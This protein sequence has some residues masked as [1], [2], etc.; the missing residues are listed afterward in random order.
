MGI[1]YQLNYG[2]DILFVPGFLL[3]QEEKVCVAKWR[4]KTPL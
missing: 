2:D 3:S 4:I 1:C